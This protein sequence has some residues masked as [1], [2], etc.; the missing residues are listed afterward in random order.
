MKKIKRFI[1]FREFLMGCFCSLP[2]LACAQVTI[3]AQLPPGGM[4]QKEQLW[5]LTLISNQTDA[6]NII[7]KFTLQD[8]F[9]NQEV[10][11]ATTGAMILSQGIKILT[12]EAAQPVFYNYDAPEFTGSFLPVG[13]YIACYQV[14]QQH[15][16]DELPLANQCIQF[17]IDPLSPPLL[18]LPD[19]NS[20]V[21]TPYP[22]FVWMPPA[23]IDMF[24]NL[25]YDILV[26]V[27]EDGQA[28]SEA[29][30]YN[31]PLYSNS[32]LTQP[33]DNY[34][35][36]FTKLDTGKVYAWQVIARNGFS[37][38]G[39]TEVWTFMVTAPTVPVNA[40][41]T[42]GYVLMEDGLRDTYFISGK[43]LNLKYNSQDNTHLGAINFYDGTGTLIQT[44]N[45]NI[46][47]GDNY[48][49]FDLS[50]SFQTNTTYT[51]S[52]TTIN[53]RSQI[54]LFNIKN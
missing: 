34:P 19:N 20:K 5:N 40:P 38:A 46:L 7:I 52:I 3:N 17:S 47:Q 39:K 49:D 2:A 25:T 51:V 28:P 11:S 9:T 30:E 18:N 1:R 27:V 13:S 48:F 41:S 32:G 21:E 42:T 35:A 53:G 15:G 37:Y 4:I 26:T 36:S 8:A 14:F 6:L 44:V 23:P 33:N 45:K 16:E 43:Q 10:M 22:V 31:T 24:S 50:A 54:L 29:I 12:N